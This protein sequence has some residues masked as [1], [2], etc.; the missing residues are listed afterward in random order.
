MKRSDD[1]IFDL[2][3]HTGEDT[4]FYLKKGFR[5]VGVEANP[6]LCSELRRTFAAE[7]ARGQFLLVEAAISESEGSGVFYQFEKTVWGTTSADWADRNEH[8]GRSYR[9][10]E[11]KYISPIHLYSEYGIPYFMK[12]DIEGADMLCIAAL[13][14]VP[15]P[16][17]LSVEAEK[18]DIDKFTRELRIISDLGYTEFQLVQQEYVPFQRLPRPP[19]EGNEIRHRFAFGSSGMF[20]ND[21]PE[22][23][24]RDFDS[25]LERYQRIVQRHSLFGD[26]AL[27]RNR[28]ARHLLRATGLYPGWHDLHAR[29]S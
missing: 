28:I 9:E 22:R 12:V 11:V 24:W 17:F 1:L 7:I 5:V 18:H 15:K 26:Y 29:L 14:D 13:H 4:A 3:V 2:G 23:R 16:K 27:G 21:L 6:D 10:V 20:G 19:R 8:M 25:T